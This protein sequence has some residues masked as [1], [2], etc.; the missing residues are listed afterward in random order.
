[1][2][3]WVYAFFIFLFFLSNR[4]TPTVVCHV[5]CV[6]V[7]LCMDAGAC[8]LCVCVCFF[9]IFF[10]PNDRILRSFDMMYAVVCC[11]CICDAV[12][13]IHI[14]RTSKHITIC[15]AAKRITTSRI[16]KHIT[17]CRAATHIIVCRPAA[18]ITINRA[19][20]HINICQKKKHTHIHTHIN[21]TYT[22]TPYKT[23]VGGGRLKNKIN[24]HT[25]THQQH[26]NAYN[27]SN[28]HRS[29]RYEKK[30][31]HTPTHKRIH[32]IK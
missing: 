28:D 27:I 1:M 15:H 21:N 5:V 16:A 19:D 23:A 25:P 3:V 8:V 13:R 26:I 12:K 20:K 32:H 14:C 31:T 17:K 2:C 18:H 4:L 6:F 10:C 30:N 11:C 22:H 9:I 24:T 29:G 7:L